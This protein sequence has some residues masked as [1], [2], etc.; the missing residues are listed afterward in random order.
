MHLQKPNRHSHR[1]KVRECGE[2]REP[3]NG[4]APRARRAGA[5]PYI[6]EKMEWLDG[7]LAEA[8]GAKVPLHHPPPPQLSPLWV[9]VLISFLARRTLFPIP[10]TRGR[11]PLAKTVAKVEQAQRKRYPV[12]PQPVLADRLLRVKHFHASPLL[13]LSTT[14]I[15]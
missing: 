11:V 13:R 7:G 5:Q 2:V 3:R 14:R 9:R 4:A 8:L 6:P 10:A 1:H 15:L 12:G